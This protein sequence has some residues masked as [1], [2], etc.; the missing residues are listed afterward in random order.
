MSMDAKEYQLPEKCR[1]DLCDLTLGLVPV[2]EL[3]E[4]QDWSD[5]GSYHPDVVLGVTLSKAEA[6]AWVRSSSKDKPRKYYTRRAVVH[7]DRIFVVQYGARA[8]D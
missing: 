7:G 3:V 1:V 2:Y 6:D 8:D 4:V 5:R